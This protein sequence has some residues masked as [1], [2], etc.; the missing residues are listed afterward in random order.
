MNIEYNIEKKKIELIT[1]KMM[2]QIT[3]KVD[4]KNPSLI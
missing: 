2:N 4:Q 1:K 3:K